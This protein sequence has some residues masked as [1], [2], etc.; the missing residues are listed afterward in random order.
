MSKNEQLLFENLALQYMDNLY[1]KAIRLA[2]STEVT[3]ILVQQTY[4]AA[5][6]VFEQFEKNRNFSKWLNGILMLIYVNADSCLK[7]SAEN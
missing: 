6:N 7:E 2:R 1:S 5:F 4:T 3:E